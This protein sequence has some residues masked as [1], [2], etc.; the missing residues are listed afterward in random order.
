MKLITSVLLSLTFC[1]LLAQKY[2]PAFRNFGPPQPVVVDETT[3]IEIQVL[4]NT[5][6]DYYP[7]LYS[8]RDVVIAVGQMVLAARPKMVLAQP[9]AAILAEGD[10]RRALESEE[11]VNT[12]ASIFNRATM[13]P[14]TWILRCYLSGSATSR[15]VGGGG[16][17]GGIEI[18]GDIETGT[19][20][21]IARYELIRREGFVTVS[22]I[23]AKEVYSSANMIGLTADKAGLF[24]GGAGLAFGQSSDPVYR[25]G[26]V[27]TDTCLFRKSPPAIARL[28][29]DLR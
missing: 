10:D 1:A 8:A 5:W 29:G 6:Y 20:T 7:E 14:A 16:R 26:I 3:P 17:V 22:A 24:G 12:N 23:M 21:A 25:R 4:G 11:F 15:I 13:K 27:S 19:S 9:T 18:G 28:L 2:D